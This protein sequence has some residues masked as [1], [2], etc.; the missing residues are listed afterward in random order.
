MKHITLTYDGTHT[1][2][3][4]ERALVILGLSNGRVVLQTA[5][6]NVAVP[7]KAYE[8]ALGTGITIATEIAVLQALA[9]PVVALWVKGWMPTTPTA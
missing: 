8:C 9:D 5:C 4:G 6:R 1:F 7:T 3:D 2:V